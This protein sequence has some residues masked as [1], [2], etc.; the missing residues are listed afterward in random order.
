MAILEAVDFEA[1]EHKRGRRVGD[2][3]LTIAHEL[4]AF[5]IG[6]VLVIAQARIGHQSSGDQVDL[7]IGMDT[8]QKTLRIQI[9]QL[10]LIGCR[11]L[12]TG[13]VAPV[14]IAR[15]FGSV[16]RSIEVCQVPVRQIA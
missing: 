1:K 15:H 12:S 14:E 4:R 9:G 5:A 2:P 13:G 11:K 16:R 10:A 6:C 7:F 3:L 8:A